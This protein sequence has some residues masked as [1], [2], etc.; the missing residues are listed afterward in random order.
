MKKLLLLTLIWC[1]QILA[2][3]ALL[4]AQTGKGPTVSI[5]G[6]VGSP[7]NLSLKD[8]KGF[9][10]IEVVR[11]DRDGKDHLYSGVSLYLLLSKAAVTLGK[12]LRGENLTKF[13]LAEASDGYQVVFALAELDPEFT[14]R[15]VILAHQVDANPLPAADG[16]FRIIVE[17]EKKPA[18]CIKQVTTL[19]IEFYK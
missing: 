1:A 10:Q 18:R 19:K 17:G 7:L 4:H 15:Q 13:M 14:D 5:T 6:E 9:K 11:K 16:P 3:S 2:P 12:D 8:L